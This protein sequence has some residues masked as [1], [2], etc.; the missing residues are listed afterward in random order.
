MPWLATHNPEIDWEKG[1]VKMIQYPP[2]CKKRKQKTQEKRQMRKTVE[3]KTVEELVS[4]KFWKWKKVFGKEE[5]ERMTTRKPQ[6]HVIELKEGFIPKKRKVYILSR[7]E[8]EEV[9]V[10]NQNYLSLLKYTLQLT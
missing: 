1:E 7:E 6:D 3:E 9:Q 5:L 2:I 10:L 8:R 4:R